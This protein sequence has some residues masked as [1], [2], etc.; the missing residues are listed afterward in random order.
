VKGSPALLNVDVPLGLKDR[1]KEDGSVKNF[2][3]WLNGNFYESKDGTQVVFRCIG[4]LDENGNTS[5]SDWDGVQKILMDALGV[6]DTLSW[7]DGCALRDSWL[8]EE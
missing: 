5:G 2:A 8:T 4:L 6:V 7:L 1:E 3:E